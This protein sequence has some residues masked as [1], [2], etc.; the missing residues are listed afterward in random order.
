MFTAPCDAEPD[1][2]EE[3]GVE[4][5][6]EEEVGVEEENEEESEE[7]TDSDHA[8]YPLTDSDPPPDG[9]SDDGMYSKLIYSTFHF[10]HF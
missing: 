3:V 10:L 5:E 1:E 7:E 8:H 6:V 2:V 9:S 4:E